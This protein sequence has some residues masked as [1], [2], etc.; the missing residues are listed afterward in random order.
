MYERADDWRSERDFYRGLIAT[1]FLS[2][3]DATTTMVS[4]MLGYRS[5]EAL[6]HAFRRAG[7]PSPGN[8]QKRL[9]P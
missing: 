8:V 5:S 6:C 1:M 9:S 2:H 4:R 7:L 3:P